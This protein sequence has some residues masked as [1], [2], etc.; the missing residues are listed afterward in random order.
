M[1]IITTTQARRALP[2]C[3]VHEHDA[4]AA[5]Q[6]RDSVTDLMRAVCGTVNSRSEPDDL[7][8]RARRPSHLFNAHDSPM[9]P[10]CHLES[11]REA[12]CQPETPAATV[13]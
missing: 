1:T 3:R 11:V 12:E 6:L 13:K 8:V 9:Y 4:E 5:A 2:G 10:A 7:T